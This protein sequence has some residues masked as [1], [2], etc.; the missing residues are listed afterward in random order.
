MTLKLKRKG[1]RLSSSN[2][3]ELHSIFP[4]SPGFEGALVIRP[5]S[6]PQQPPRKKPKQH[7]LKVG[8]LSGSGVK[9][10]PRQF[11]KQSFP[12]LL[13]VP[14]WANWDRSRKM[15]LVSTPAARL[16]LLGPPTALSHMWLHLAACVVW[17]R[18][19][20]LTLGEKKRGDDAL[21]SAWIVF[22]RKESN[23]SGAAQLEDGRK[24]GFH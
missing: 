1:L 11:Q 9:D 17:T 3:E 18:V 8:S 14:S 2:K 12:A 19:V 4:P 21:M 22:E 20:S 15:F 24:F 6:P 5:T 16:Q 23:G 10:L 13:L 7:R